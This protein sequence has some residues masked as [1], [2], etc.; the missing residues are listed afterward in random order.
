M[1]EE[2]GND[3]AMGMEGEQLAGRFGAM[4][5]EHMASMGS[6]TMSMAAE[7]MEFQDFQM[8]GGDSAFGMMEAMGMDNVMGMEGDQMAG[9]FSAMEGHHIQDMGAERRLEAYQSMGVERGG[10]G[11]PRV[12][13]MAPGGETR[14]ES[15]I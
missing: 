8:M 5:S 10:A 12:G 7:K 15:G 11:L 1:L 9:M 6:E 13:H 3:M 14:W 4:G 2:K